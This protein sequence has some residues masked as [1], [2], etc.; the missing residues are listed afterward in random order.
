M[1]AHTSGIRTF[2][3]RHC[4]D[5]AALISVFEGE[6]RLYTLSANERLCSAGEE[7]ESVWIVE[8]GQLKVLA[9]ESIVWRGAGE[10]IGEMAFLRGQAKATPLRGNDVVA[11]CRTKV[12]KIDRATLD[13]LDP[14]TRALWYETVARVLVTKLDEASLL[15]ASQ[16]RDLADGDRIIERLVCPE[17]VQATS[18]FLL[19]G[20]D[21]IPP[22]KKTAVI[23]FSDL[24]GFSAHSEGLDASEV[25][26]VLRRLTDPQVEEIQRAK[27]QVDKHMGDAVMAFWLCPDDLR[28]ERS[29]AGATRAALEAARRVTDIAEASALPIGIRIGLHVGEVSVGDFGGGD[30]IAFTIVGQPV[31]AAARYEQYRHDPGQ[32]GGRVRVSDKVFARLPDDVRSAFQPTAVEFPDKHDRRFVAYLSSI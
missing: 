13:G 19:N 11:A 14:T 18:A 8:E 2:L 21:R 25:G 6:H 23:W 12:W 5:P 1:A 30:R 26:D 31:N 24:S 3:Q 28:V 29:L 22:V 17:G 16:A 15:R 27:G 10:I 32:P 20:A 9:G 4:S 7:A